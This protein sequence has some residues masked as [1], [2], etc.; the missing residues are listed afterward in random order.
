MVNTLTSTTVFSSSWSPGNRSFASGSL[1]PLSPLSNL[2]T[3]ISV[4]F[5]M[6]AVKFMNGVVII[7]GFAHNSSSVIVLTISTQS[8]VIFLPC[9]NQKQK[10]T[11]TNKQKNNEQR[12]MSGIV[13]HNIYIL[14][15]FI[16]GKIN[17]Q[18][19]INQLKQH[20]FTRLPCGS[21]TD[22]GCKICQVPL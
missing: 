15:F 11:T 14:Y 1:T 20:C 7:V 3:F 10:Y 22:N 21:P 5:S 13:L 19:K 8:L 6:Q 9:K 16:H 18:L 2:L 12:E 17:P 4:A